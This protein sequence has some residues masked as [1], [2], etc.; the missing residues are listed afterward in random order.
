[1]NT[2]IPAPIPTPT[3]A[4]KI[5]SWSIYGVIGAAT[6]A[7]ML[8][9]WWS[10]QNPMVLQTNNTPFP[11]RPNTNIPGQIEYMAVDYCKTY[12]ASGTVVARMVG[13]KSIIRI[14]WPVESSTPQCLKTEVPIVIPSYATG[15]TYYFDFTITYKINPLKQKTVYFRS[16]SF[17]LSGQLQTATPRT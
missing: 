9:G 3:K 11:V 16:Q 4:Q 6:L 13:Q 12:H 2:I 17:T 14:P 10:L 7:L 15:D 8:L 5:I 1:M